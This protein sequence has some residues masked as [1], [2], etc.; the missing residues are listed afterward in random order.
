M[1]IVSDNVSPGRR[2]Q[3]VDVKELNFVGVQ[4]G[5]IMF[6]SNLFNNYNYKV[7]IESKFI[8]FVYNCRL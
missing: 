5:S 3:N 7:H 6:G 2:L 8:S 4:M 1:I